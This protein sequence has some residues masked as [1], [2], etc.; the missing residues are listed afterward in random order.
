M[1]FTFRKK[2]QQ[3]SEEFLV[4]EQTKW[5]AGS[6]SETFEEVILITENDVRSQNEYETQSVCIEQIAAVNE[7][8]I[9]ESKHSEEESKVT[10]GTVQSV[11]VYDNLL[12]TGLQNVEFQYSDQQFFGTLKL[13]EEGLKDD[14]PILIL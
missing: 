8:N 9:E 14:L 12:L 10:E 4:S 1:S 13:N 5:Q 11:E 2:T 7:A 3:N 6:E